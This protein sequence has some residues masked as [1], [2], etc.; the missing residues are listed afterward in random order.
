MSDAKRLDVQFGVEISMVEV[1][2]IKDKLAQLRPGTAE[3]STVFDELLSLR[4][5]Y[6]GRLEGE[7]AA[8]MNIARKRLKE[9]FDVSAG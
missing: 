2:A 3:Y 6:G 7:C 9:T 8:Y 1:N 5:Y 4:K